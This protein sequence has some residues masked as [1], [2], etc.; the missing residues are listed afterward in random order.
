MEKEFKC[1]IQ[2]QLPSVSPFFLCGQNQEQSLYPAQIP[3][4]HLAECEA[5][6]IWRMKWED[7]KSAR[8]LKMNIFKT[9]EVIQII[10]KSNSKK[11]ADKGTHLSWT[12]EAAE[13]AELSHSQRPCWTRCPEAFW[14]Y[15]VTYFD[16]TRGWSSCLVSH[17]CAGVVLIKR[18]HKGNSC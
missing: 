17:L 16:F 12:R 3:A 8:S 5:K 2:K 10:K 1:V 15:G 9:G 6:M 7:V 14:N 4:L 13:V 18:H 11:A